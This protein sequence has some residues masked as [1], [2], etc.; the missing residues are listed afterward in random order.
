VI[1]LRRLNDPDEEYLWQCV[2]VRDG[3]RC[4]VCNN[5][6]ESGCHLVAC[7]LCSRTYHVGCLR[8]L[9]A[10]RCP[11]RDAPFTRARASDDEKLAFVRT[12]WLEA[13]D[14]MHL[15]NAANC[16]PWPPNGR[17]AA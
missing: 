3:A 13:V 17:R 16:P 14:W 15:I 4:Q 7:V 1:V 2:E 8:R 10:H 9:G 12:A 6:V 5:P 11:M